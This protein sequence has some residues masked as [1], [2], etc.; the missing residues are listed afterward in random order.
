MNSITFQKKT[1]LWSKFKREQNFN[2]LYAHID[3][4]PLYEVTNMEYV[5]V[6]WVKKPSSERSSAENQNKN[7]FLVFWSPKEVPTTNFNC[8]KNLLRILLSLFPSHPKSASFSEISKSRGLFASEAKASHVLYQQV[9]LLWVSK[10]SWRNRF[11]FLLELF[12]FEKKN[13]DFVQNLR[14]NQ[15]FR[16]PY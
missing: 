1:I 16:K 5:Y 12:S 15:V 7:R 4:N 3:S 14:R 11:I 10:K 13:F 6:K 9:A 8:P 2:F